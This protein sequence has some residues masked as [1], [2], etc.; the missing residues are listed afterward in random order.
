MLRGFE[1]GVEQMYGYASFREYVVRVFDVGARGA[2]DR[3]RTARQLEALPVLSEAC[4][5]GRVLYAITREL[6]RVATPETEAEWLAAAAGKT[7][8]EVQRMVSG[9]RRG[10]RPN[11]KKKPESVVED[12]VFH[13]VAPHARALLEQVRVRMAKASGEPV[14]DTELL[15]AMA[16]ALLS[17]DA[18]VEGLLYAALRAAPSPCAR[19]ATE[20]YRRAA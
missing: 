3:I 4:R 13:R 18:T 5:E 17:A 7:S 10:D 11:E 12:V 19:E 2:E 15:E 14:D 8:R 9:L 20:E 6:T 16:H 1:V